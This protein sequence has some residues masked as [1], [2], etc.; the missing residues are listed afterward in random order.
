MIQE[1]TLRASSKGSIS[2]LK[3]DASKGDDCHRL[4]EQA[5]RDFKRIDILFNNVGIQP[6]TSNVPIHEL[7]ESMW[8]AIMDVN[9]KSIF[10][11]CKYT[12]PYMIQQKSG[13]II[14]NASIQGLSSQKGVSAYAASKG[15]ILAIT[16]QLAVEYGKYS[17]RVNTVSPGTIM[18]ALA[19]ENSKSMQPIIDN[20]PL[21]RIGEPSDIA[22][23]VAFL[24]SDQSKWVTGQNMVV[25]GGIT[26]KGGWAE[27][28]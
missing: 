6:G 15:G 27:L 2:F 14:N 11:M 28:P 12:L 23:M 25:D 18:T 19:L 16:R 7:E 10:W 22:S 3:F 4:V 20:T 5:A 1:W 8:D 13:S 21:R 17:I 9:L 24:A 26:I